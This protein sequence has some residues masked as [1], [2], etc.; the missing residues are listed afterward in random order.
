MPQTALFEQATATVRAIARRHP[1]ILLLDDL[2]WVDRGSSSLLFHLGQRLA[3]SAILVV[4]AYRPEEVA[5]DREGE[6]HPLQS[7]VNELRRVLGETPVDLGQAEGRGFVEALLDSEP[8]CLGPEFR[9]MRFRQTGGHALFTVELLQELRDRNDLVKDEGGR[10]VEGQTLDWA[11]LP[12]KVEAAIAER[13]GQLPASLSATLAVASVEG[14]EFTA[15]VVARVQG[16]EEE[17]IARALSGALSRRYQ[18]VLPQSFRRMDGGT[19]SRYRFRHYL[20]QQ[21][22]YG[23]PDE[24]ERA[25]LHGSVGQALETLHRAGSEE[26]T[27]QLAWHFELAGLPEKA[28]SYL[29]QAASMAGRRCGWEEAVGHLG[30]ALSLLKG[31]P[32]TPERSRQEMAIHMALGGAIQGSPVWATPERAEA[33]ERAYQLCRQIGAEDQVVRSL[34]LLADVSRI[35][36]QLW[37]SLEICEQ[38]LSIA[39][40]EVEPDQLVLAHYSMGETLYFLGNLVPARHHLDEAMRHYDPSRHASLTSLA[41]ADVGVTA[42]TWTAWDMVSLG[43]PKQARSRANEAL[44]LA[45]ELQDPL[46]L[47]FAI[48]L[49]GPGFELISRQYQTPLDRTAELAALVAEK[50]L[51]VMHPWLGVLEGRS[52]VARGEIAEGLRQMRQATDA[53]QANGSP[54]GTMLQLLIQAEVCLQHERWPEAGR[55]LEEAR[56][57][58]E[59]IEER[60][61][62]AE[63]HR[64]RAAV[65][66][67]SGADTGEA[68]GCFRKAIEVARRQKAKGWELRA[69]TGLARLWGRHGRQR[70]AHELLAPIYGWFTEGF[71]TRD[72]VEA[73]ALLAELA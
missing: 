67:S 14:E 65:L 13:V 7:V 1:L 45:R 32:D 26:I 19:L 28:V 55:A 34:F 69:A 37:K 51:E 27:I 22:L 48:A 68:E 18:V 38:M 5:Q 66:L 21:Y 60:G 6:R 40:R 70:E 4:G 58:M 33:C 8:N 17:K 72:L 30:R 56:G 10:W 61:L 52:L 41:G 20:F 11:R 9:R 35:Q 16:I 42:L 2:Q 36:G 23:Q 53:W 64:L 47:A 12:V 49:A 29:V 62:E 25:R 71:D 73:R 57:V 3:G 39:E 43:Y 24:V 50:R 46:T 31:L 54:P 15:E 63:L 44:R 59:R